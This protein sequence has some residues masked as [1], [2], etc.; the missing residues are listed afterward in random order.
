MK[1]EI[2]CT[3]ENTKLIEVVEFIIKFQICLNYVWQNVADKNFTIC[4]TAVVYTKTIR[5]YTHV[6]LI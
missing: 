5:Y 4:E 2:S 6:N 1:N 3:Y